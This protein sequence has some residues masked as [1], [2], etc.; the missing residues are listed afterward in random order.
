MPATVRLIESKEDGQAVNLHEIA[1]AVCEFPEKYPQ[2]LEAFVGESERGNAHAFAAAATGFSCAPDCE[3]TLLAGIVRVWREHL[4][5]HEIDQQLM[6]QVLGRYPHRPQ[7]VLGEIIDLWAAKL[8]ST[9]ADSVAH[10]LALLSF[11]YSKNPIPMRARGYS[12]VARAAT[13]ALARTC[14]R[15]D[16]PSAFALSHIPFAM[17]QCREDVNVIADEAREIAKVCEAALTHP[18]SSGGATARVRRA[19]AQQ[20]RAATEA[21]HDDDSGV[22][23]LETVIDDVPEISRLVDVCAQ[24]AAVE[25]EQ[26]ARAVASVLWEGEAQRERTLVDAAARARRSQYREALLRGHNP[27]EGDRKDNEVFR[28]LVEAALADRKAL[29]QWMAEVTPREYAGLWK[30]HGRRARAGTLY[31]LLDERSVLT[32][33]QEGFAGND[34]AEN[35]FDALAFAYALRRSML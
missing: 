27:E 25:A 8:P 7:G 21:T 29:C 18:N 15:E 9:D 16:D 10:V 22:K 19:C 23:V 26:R 3:N 28:V 6:L 31:R 20:L 5:S 30:V 17:L 2:L 4:Q 34:I 12:K 33:L 1:R 11:W 13:D 35:V 14:E 32:A 24:A